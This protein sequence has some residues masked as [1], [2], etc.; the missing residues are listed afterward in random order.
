M[1]SS[2]RDEASNASFYYG[3]ARRPEPAVRQQAIYFQFD[4]ALFG[5]GLP[6]VAKRCTSHLLART[7][8]FVTAA[9]LLILFLPL[10]LATLAAIRLSGARP[11][12]R[13]P[14]AGRAWCNI[15]MPDV[16]RMVSDADAVSDRLLASS[17][18][19]RAESL[20]GHK[21]KG[22]RVSRDSVA[23]CGVRA[24]TSF[25]N[26]GTCWRYELG[27][28]AP[29]TQKEL[30]RTGTTCSCTRPRGRACLWQVS[31]RSSTSCCGISV[32]GAPEWTCGSCAGLSDPAER[33]GRV[34]VV[35][36]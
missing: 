9:S 28:A 16:P 22:I 25:R 12:C 7:F 2:F 23:C 4:N 26:S 24:R 8:D 19:L 21:L 15:R 1:R 30:L 11:I 3:I 32:T 10:I 33:V 35:V 6:P 13:H 18:K 36:I 29:V 31:G 20:H 17:S 5:E 34:E 14:R 27:R